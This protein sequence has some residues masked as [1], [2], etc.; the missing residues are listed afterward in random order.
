MQ[1]M[2]HVGQE[3]QYGWEPADPGRI[4]K[5]TA[6]YLGIGRKEPEPETAELIRWAVREI[7]NAAVPACTSCETELHLERDGQIQIGPELFVSH[8]L[9]RNLKDCGR[10]ILFAATLGAPADR[11]IQ[12]YSRLNMAGAVALQAAAAAVL[13]DYCDSRNRRLKEQASA[14]G[15]YLRPRFSP[16]YGDF[17]ISFQ[18]TLLAMLAAEK[19]IGLTVTDA[20]ILVPVKSVTAVIGMGRADTECTP[21]GCEACKKTDCVYRRN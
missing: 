12:K 10:V 2:E 6:R 20:Y 3:K 8:D 16:G 4:L 18:K 1:R 5:E 9:A 15:W 14:S 7:E 19:R 21:K 17:P 13:E 11:L